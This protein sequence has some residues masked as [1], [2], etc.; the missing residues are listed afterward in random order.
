MPFEVKAHVD[1]HILTVTA[2]TAQEALAKAVEW[3]VTKKLVDVSISDGFKRYSIPEFSSA[4]AEAE[5][6]I[7]EIEMKAKK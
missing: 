2:E 1:D 5:Q 7:S 3:Q 4:V 6:R